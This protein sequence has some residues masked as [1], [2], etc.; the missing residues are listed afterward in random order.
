MDGEQDMTQSEI[1]KTLLK[2]FGKQE[3]RQV[4]EEI[5]RSENEEN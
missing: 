2:P 3:K 1:T 5:I 4:G